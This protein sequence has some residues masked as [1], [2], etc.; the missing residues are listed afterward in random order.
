M[1]RNLAL[2]GIT[3]KSEWKSED[4]EASKHTIGS[5]ILPFHDS[6]DALVWSDLLS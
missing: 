5:P 2:S 6:M 4:G 1:N 3:I